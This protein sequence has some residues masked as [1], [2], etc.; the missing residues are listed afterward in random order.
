M[1]DKSQKKMISPVE[2]TLPIQ[3]KILIVDDS[4]GERWVLSNLM[5]QAGFTPL[6]VA[7]G[8]EALDCIR[9]DAPDAMLLDVGLPGMNGFEVLERVNAYDKTMPVIMVT[10]NGKTHD[11][12]RAVRAGAW[13][14]VTK[15]FKNED[16]VLTL[17][18]AIEEQALKCQVREIADPTHRADSLLNTM[19]NSKAIQ[20]I[21]KEV[22]RVAETNFSILVIGESGTGKELVSQA[23]HTR[24]LRAAKPLVA[25]DC[26]AIS[27]SLIESELFGH[28][29]GA[30]TGAYQAKKGAFELADGGT[31]F[32]DE[33]GNLPMAMQGKL[34]RVLE[35][36]RIHRIG[37]DKEQEVDFRVVAA[38][39]A[40]LLAMVEKKT[41]RGDLYHRLAEYTICIPPL[42]ERKEDLAF[43]VH[44]FLVLTNKELGKQ[45]HGLSASAWA[46]VQEYHWPGNARELRNQLRRAVLVCDG[47]DGMMTPENLEMLSRHSTSLESL[48]HGFSKQCWTEIG[49]TLACPLRGAEELLASGAGL[50]L[51]ELTVRIHAQVERM[52]L[53]RTLAL[54]E[55][56]KAKAA[57]MLH[58]D[59]K[60][61]HSKLKA[62]AISS[63]QFMKDAYAHEGD[64][65]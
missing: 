28:E 56:N 60:T 18:C 27:E 3:A 36:R 62:Y 11:A 23:I 31:I 57:R 64:E 55:G 21:Q 17:R 63:N 39:N 7:S 43:L 2:A 61:I 44:R 48:D 6:A 13:D 47:P 8:E 26:G 10:A 20:G 1:N 15:P 5:R 52:I 59:Y 54:T 58:I 53:L 32:L 19:G 42:R 14:Y 65:H 38:T 9:Q 24:S 16:V 51:T 41:F 22:A 4:E 46:L 50:S 40:D 35:T 34:L 45:V 37:S 29:K 49:G 30:F 12:V 25:V 33:I